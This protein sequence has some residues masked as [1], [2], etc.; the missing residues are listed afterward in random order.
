MRLIAAIFFILLLPVTV[1]QAQDAEI[2]DLV[3]SNSSRELLLYCRVDNAFSA[4]MEEAVANGIPVTFTFFVELARIRHNW[5]DDEVVSLSFD[6]IL[7]W[8]ALKEE[9]TVVLGEHGGRRLTT[10]SLLEAR[11]L[12]GQ[13]TEV[14]V[15]PLE[16]LRE[17]GDYL[18][19][20]KARLNKKTLPF[21]I[22][23]LIPF[24]SLWD[25]HTDWRSVVFRY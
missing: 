3:V 5:P 25:F 4:E 8:D 24:F 19:R 22:H 15:V 16:R 14:A 9:Y 17:E 2:N 12:M 21:N 13:V 11:R 20:V 1:C 23:Y 18:L 10:K 7:S 6:H